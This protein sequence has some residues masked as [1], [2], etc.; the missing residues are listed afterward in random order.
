MWS[1]KKSPPDPNRITID[2]E[3]RTVPIHQSPLVR[4]FA[5]RSQPFSYMPYDGI[6][7]FIAKY[8][9]DQQNGNSLDFGWRRRDLREEIR[10]EENHAARNEES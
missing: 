2:P 10:R 7:I 8:I 3:P 4:I 1:V 6:D 9:R 5:G